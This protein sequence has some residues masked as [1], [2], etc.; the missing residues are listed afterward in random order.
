MIQNMMILEIFLQQ[1]DIE[2]MTAREQTELERD[3]APV[4]IRINQQIWDV[5]VAEDVPDDP[6]VRLQ[7]QMELSQMGLELVLV[8]PHVQP[9]FD[10]EA[11]HRYA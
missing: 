1:Q 5:V 6:G 11:D 2:W 10:E 4:I 8:L 7:K 9:V 3:V